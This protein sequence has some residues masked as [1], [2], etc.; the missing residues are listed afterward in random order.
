[1]QASVSPQSASV[2]QHPVWL[3]CVHW[4]APASQVSVVQA[5]P[6]SQL[7]ASPAAHRPAWQVSIPL[8]KLP[9]VQDVPSATGVLLHL[10]F[11]HA[12]AVHAW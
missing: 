10:P 1:V 2:L 7:G 8:Q 6:S 9:S 4:L 12:S 11:T 5:L 3:S